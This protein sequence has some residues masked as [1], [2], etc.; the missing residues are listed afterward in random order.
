MNS[1]LRSLIHQ[2]DPLRESERRPAQFQLPAHHS[3]SAALCFFRRDR[4]GHECG[5]AS[6][7]ALARFGCLR[8]PAPFEHHPAAYTMALRH[9]V[10]TQLAAFF[11]DRGFF[12]FTLTLPVADAPRLRER[13][14]SNLGD[15]RTFNCVT[16]LT[17]LIRMRASHCVENE[18]R[19]DHH[20]LAES[21][22]A[23]GRPMTLTSSPHATSQARRPDIQQRRVEL[24]EQDVNGVRRL[25]RLSECPD[26][27]GVQRHRPSPGQAS[28]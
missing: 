22:M 18:R 25:K 1:I 26:R 14:S 7:S 9:L 23:G 16:I 28:A 11:N 13:I 4:H 2:P 20:P 12:V 10:H 19:D 8:L 17:V 3:R 21:E 27:I 5:P 6:A 24:F 15:W